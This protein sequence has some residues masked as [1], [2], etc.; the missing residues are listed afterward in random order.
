MEG[1]FQS[2][3]TD[4]SLVYV[5]PHSCFDLDHPIDFTLMELMLRE[6]LLDFKL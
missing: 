4:K 2:S 3:I 6:D 5:M 1:D